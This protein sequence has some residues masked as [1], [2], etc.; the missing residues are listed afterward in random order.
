MSE[1]IRGIFVAT[2]KSVAERMPCGC[3]A[4]SSFEHTYPNLQR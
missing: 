1:G 4:G 2:D 3:A